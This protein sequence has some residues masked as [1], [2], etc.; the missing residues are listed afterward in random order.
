MRLLLVTLIFL[1]VAGCSM[2]GEQGPGPKIVDYQPQFGG[3][4]FP[5]KNK[6][7]NIKGLT[8]D[9][10]HQ[11]FDC[12]REKLDSAFARPLAAFGS[13]I[14]LWFNDRNWTGKPGTNRRGNG[15]AGRNAVLCSTLL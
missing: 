1:S 2:I 13:V 15:V 11:T 10:L 5:D 3:C 9:T 7:E 12:A 14:G 6:F 4:D 8:A